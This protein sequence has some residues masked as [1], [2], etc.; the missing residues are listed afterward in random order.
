MEETALRLCKRRRRGDPTQQQLTTRSEP[1]TETGESKK[2]EQVG[3][4]GGDRPGPC[5]V[6]VADDGA[7]WTEH[8]GR[9]G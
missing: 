3:K 4:N 6:A 7:L 1:N 2:C 8:T 5:P 9:L